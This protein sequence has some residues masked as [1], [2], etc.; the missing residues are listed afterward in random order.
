[1][2]EQRNN[3]TQAPR[4]VVTAKS[5]P[6]T[7]LVKGHNGTGASATMLASTRVHIGPRPASAYPPAMPNNGKAIAPPPTPP[8]KNCSS[9]A[10]G[11]ANT[12][13]ANSNGAKTSFGS[14]HGRATH[15]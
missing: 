7:P 14:S 5:G 15:P 10:A 3:A 1:M 13:T 9:N 6:N 8:A 12:P 11:D 4:A 2:R